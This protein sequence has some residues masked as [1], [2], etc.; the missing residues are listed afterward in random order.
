MGMLDRL[1][2]K[3]LRRV[4]AHTEVVP[5]LARFATTNL[6][7]ALALA[8]VPEPAVPVLFVALV[9]LDVFTRSKC[10]WEVGVWFDWGDLTGVLWL[11][12]WWSRWRFM[13]W[14]NR[15]GQALVCPPTPMPTTVKAVKRLLN[16]VNNHK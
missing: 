1:P 3:E 12:W 16:N 5:P 8:L 9:P 11:D 15:E 6:A 10:D 7:L 14:A 4:R 2:N 13:A